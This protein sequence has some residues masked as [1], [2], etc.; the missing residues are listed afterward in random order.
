[1][2]MAT[3][4]GHRCYEL[5]DPMP[6]EVREGAR[7]F[8]AVQ[9]LNEL[10]GVLQYV[11]WLDRAP[12]H[13][14][15]QMLMA[16]IQDEVGHGHVV[17]RVAED[18]GMP[19]EQILLDYLEGRTRIHNIFHY[20]FATWE[21]VGPGLLLTNSAAI[22]QF[23]SLAK[24]VYLPYARALRKVEREES[25]HYQHALDLTHE[26]LTHGDA[27]QR[28]RVQEG[29]ELWLPR[30]LAY[31]GPPDTDTLHTNRMWQVGL[32]PDGNDEVR[33]A[34]LNKIIPVVRKLGLHVDPSLVRQAPSGEWEFE[35]PDWAQVKKVIA[36][37]GPSSQRRLDWVRNALDRNAPYRRA[38]Q[39]VA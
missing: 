14:R 20:S 2:P 38:L 34:W 25:F 37:G 23:Q 27:E 13:T 15:R 1:M 39:G 4:A 12:S 17:A 36:N 30:I 8:A 35:M 31:L 18:L 3:A 22:T 11:E 19:R 16:K 33:Q 32:K 5:W 10:V 9:A 26:I 7:R 29:F 24:G 6:D 28:R 21:E